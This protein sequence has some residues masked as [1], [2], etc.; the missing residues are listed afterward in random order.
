MAV[1]EE[2]VRATQIAVQANDR[3]LRQVLDQWTEIENSSESRQQAIIQQ[4]TMCDGSTRPA[5]HAWLAD[6]DLAN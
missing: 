1:P 6:L 4:T 5:V 2:Y 3:Q